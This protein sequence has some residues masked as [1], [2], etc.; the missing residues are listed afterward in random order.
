MTT[1]DVI[2]ALTEYE[3]EHG[4]KEILSGIS[5][6]HDVPRIFFCVTFGAKRKLEKVYI[7]K[8]GGK[9]E[10]NY[11]GK[12]QEKS[13]ENVQEK[14]AHYAGMKIDVIEFCLA[15]R[16]DF[17]PGNVIKYLCRY[18]EKGGIEDLKKARNY[19]DRMIADE[20]KKRQ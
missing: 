5:L 19:I 8:N 2:N 17:A 10:E 18:K 7:P 6:D 11:T 4:S 9:L 1:R 3:A 16:I 13:A 20:E 14:P 12:A 15:N